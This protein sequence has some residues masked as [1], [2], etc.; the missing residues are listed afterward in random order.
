[1]AEVKDGKGVKLIAFYLPQFHAI[2]L[3]DQCW[4]KG[5]TE[6]TKSTSIIFRA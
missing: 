5:F 4:G 6:W 2:P 1:M 3:N